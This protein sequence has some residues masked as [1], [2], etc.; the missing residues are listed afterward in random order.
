MKASEALGW[1]AIFEGYHVKKSEVH[2]M[3]QRGG[4]VESH[5]RFGNKIFSPL[6]HWGKADFL[7]P[8]SKDEAEKF[9]GI[10][11]NGG[12]D[13]TGILSCA[14]GLPENKK[15]LN[16]YMLGRLSKDLPIQ[17]DSWVKAIK[18]VFKKNTGDN[19]R[20]FLKAR[21]EK[22]DLE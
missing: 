6:I 7:V 4:S 13:L 3:A 21:R 17:K 11:K 9:R 2:G 20:I 5:L 16:V 8:F 12:K 15:L 14:G 1:A 10:I 18:K 19:I 22:N